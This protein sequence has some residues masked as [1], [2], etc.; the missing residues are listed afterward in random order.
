M[1]IAYGNGIMTRYAYDPKTF[2]LMHLRTEGFSKPADL[3]YHHTGQPLQEFGYEYDLV[4]NILG[5]HDRT[6]G[7]G[8][9]ARLRGIDALDRKF[10]YDALY[11]LQSATG[12]ECDQP[13][14]FPWDD[15]PRCTDL[16][17]TRS[18]T[19][20]YLYDLVGNIEQL[21]HLAEWRRGFTRD[22]DLVPGNNRLRTMNVGRD[23]L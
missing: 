1:L 21:K 6:P 20:Q 2:R 17:K 10:T 19:E 5:I 4:G 9:N 14:D 16:T 3:T 8:I 11:R 7:S 12:R 18:Y 22:F 13:P 15:A 23:R